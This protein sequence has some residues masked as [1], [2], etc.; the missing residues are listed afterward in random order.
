MDVIKVMIVDDQKYAQQGIKAH[1]ADHPHIQVVETA[2]NRNFC[3]GYAEQ[4]RPDVVLMD[5]D[6]GTEE[7]DGTQLTSELLEKYPNI[8]VIIISQHA[9]LWRM[10][11]AA[12][13]GAVGYV[14]KGIEELDLVRGVEQVV[15]GDVPFLNY[16]MLS[17]L[18]T[19]LVDNPNEPHHGGGVS[20]SYPKLTP[21]EK[22]VVHAIV[23]GENLNYTDIADYLV[24]SAD[25]VREHVGAICVKWELKGNPKIAQIFAFAIRH[26]NLWDGEAKKV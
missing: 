6:F 21:A 14:T 10:S 17:K 11:K 3:M 2:S 7:Y 9:D 18:W 25:S 12:K 26:K 15:R 16:D 23:H 19:W 13:C 4:H 22:K 8:K 20:L 24:R 5:F 1:F